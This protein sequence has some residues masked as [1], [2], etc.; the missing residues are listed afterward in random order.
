MNPTHAEEAKSFRYYDV[1]MAAFVALLLC[2]DLIG[3]SKVCVVYGFTFG[4]TILFF[5]LTYLFGDILTEVYGFKRSRKVVWA[6]F[7]AMLFASFV[8]WVMIHLPPAPGW[9]HQD[10]LVQ[11][12]GANLRLVAASLSGYFAGELTNSVVLAKMKILTQGKWLWTRLVGSTLV[13]EGVDSIIFFP[14]AFYG[15]WPNDLLLKVMFGNY[16]IKVIWEVVMIP[17]T[18]RIVSFLKKAENE[19]F[20]DYDTRFS[21][22]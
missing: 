20:Y 12:F 4:G 10:A 5:P 2:S 9:D 22:I 21:L 17:F 1:I 11:V 3:A 6:G 8:T 7:I 16:L 14:L 13:G 15:L 19:D 18:Y